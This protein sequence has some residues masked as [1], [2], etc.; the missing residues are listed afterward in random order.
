M[1]KFVFGSARARACEASLPPGS[2]GVTEDAGSSSPGHRTNVRFR[3]AADRNQL[4]ARP[5][6][7]G[8]VSGICASCR[9]E[10]NTKQFSATAPKGRSGGH[11]NWERLAFWLFVVFSFAALAFAIYLISAK[12]DGRKGF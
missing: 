12:C 4:A 2:N 6:L 9:P 10:H 1:I 3:S 11:L 8:R 7:K 5:K